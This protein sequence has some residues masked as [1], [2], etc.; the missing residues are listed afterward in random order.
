MAGEGVVVTS[1]ANHATAAKS[2]GTEATHRGR[3]RTGV[4]YS[5][6]PVT[7]SQPPPS[8]IAADRRTPILRAIAGPVL[9]LV[10][11]AVVVAACA[12]DDGSTDATVR[13]TVAAT[14]T[15]A[16]SATTASSS[17]ASTAVATTIATTIAAATTTAAASPTT[18]VAA[19]AVFED[20]TTWP[21]LGRSI[22]GAA[23]IAVYAFD[24]VPG[25]P[26]VAVAFNGSAPAEPLT[27]CQQAGDPGVQLIGDRL[28]V[29]GVTSSGTKIIVRSTS[30]ELT[31]PTWPWGAGR[32]YAAVLPPGD[33]LLAV[34]GAD[35]PAACPY[36]PLFPAVA[37][38]YATPPTVSLT[39]LDCAGGVA[40]VAVNSSPAGPQGAGAI[41]VREGDR[42]RVVNLGTLLCE[43][44]TMD[45]EE[46]RACAAIGWPR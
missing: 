46:A 45:A 20:P 41:A 30:L 33:E 36:R 43:P 24:Q 15:A 9:A 5:W 18:A 16:T 12:S 31:V 19:G 29:S 8:D 6:P 13:S 25:R 26:C 37:A 38:L 1:W 17:S 35:V 39:V 44:G 23:D 28:V 21:R 40:G 42:F 22:V 3:I 10:V 4:R 32:A 11:G 7:P 27:S 34:E 2:T 14:T